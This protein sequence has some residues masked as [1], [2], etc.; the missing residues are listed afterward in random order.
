[1]TC[2]AFVCSV[3]AQAHGEQRSATKLHSLISDILQVFVAARHH[4]PKHRRHVLFVTLMST[5]GARDFLPVL[6]LLIVESAVRGKDVP[7]LQETDDVMEK[8]E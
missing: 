5:V 3:Y 7:A 8:V 6:M 1:M 4:I 2:C